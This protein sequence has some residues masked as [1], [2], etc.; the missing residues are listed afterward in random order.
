MSSQPVLRRGGQIRS[1]LPSL[2][3]SIAR[4]DGDKFVVAIHRPVQIKTGQIKTGNPRKNATAE[5][6]LQS[7]SRGFRSAGPGRVRSCA[8]LYRQ[9]LPI[10]SGTEAAP[11]YLR[12]GAMRLPLQASQGQTC[13][14][15]QAQ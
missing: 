14:P 13:R 9:A 4:S 2:R 12:R 3:S 8:P 15:A 5:H 7:V 6:P 10:E 1:D 11:A